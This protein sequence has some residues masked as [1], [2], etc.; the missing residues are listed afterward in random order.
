M[1]GTLDFV[2]HCS[3]CRE[4]HSHQRVNLLPEPVEINGT[5]YTHYFICPNTKEMV[6]VCDCFG[7]KE[8]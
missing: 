4:N 3:S 1:R 2:E 6:Y 7:Y 8:G 5:R